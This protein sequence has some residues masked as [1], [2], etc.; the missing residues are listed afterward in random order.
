MI[1]TK[2]YLTVLGFVFLITCS[3]ALRAATPQGWFLEGNKPDSYEAG[4]DK[5]V[6]Y[7]GHPSGYLKCTKPVAATDWAMLV[8]LIRADSYLGKRVRFSGFVR[9][10]AST[11]ASP[12]ISVSGKKGGRSQMTGR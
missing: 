4:T 6:V 1:S 2:R 8:Q 11:G 12:W 5:R 9:T 10:E 3:I 7:N